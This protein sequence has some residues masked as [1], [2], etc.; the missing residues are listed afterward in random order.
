[1]LSAFSF[2]MEVNSMSVK[3]GVISIIII[4][5]A[6]VGVLYLSAQGKI[7]AKV[8]RDIGFQKVQ[9][10]QKQRATNPIEKKTGVQFPRQDS[11]KK[12]NPFRSTGTT[13]ET[14]DEFYQ[15]IIENNIFRPLGW[16]PPKKQPDYTLIG[17]AVSQHASDSKAFI[18]DRRSN[19]LHIVKLGDT[20]DDVRVKQIQAKQVTLHKKGKDI[21]LRGGRLQFF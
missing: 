16:H 1:M 5:L 21:I 10:S 12:Q 14:P 20:L 15:F 9:S 3:T 11:I 4:L 8:H 7:P 19:R 17:T 6:I 18:L 13:L 2:V